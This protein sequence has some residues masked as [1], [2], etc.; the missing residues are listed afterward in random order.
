MPKIRLNNI[1]DQT[2]VVFVEPWAGASEEHGHSVGAVRRRARA[3][4]CDGDQREPGN[5]KGLADELPT[6]YQAKQAAHARTARQRRLGDRV[7][8]TAI[9]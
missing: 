3:G 8:S 9:S 5:T 6:P 2:V 1:S 4:G 7:T